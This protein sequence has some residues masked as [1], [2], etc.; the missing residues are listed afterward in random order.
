MFLLFLISFSVIFVKSRTIKDIFEKIKH[1]FLDEI[2]NNENNEDLYEL[3]NYTR[4]NPQDPDYFYVPIF[5]TSDIHGHF[6][7]EEFDLDEYQ[8]S[9]GGLD[10][11][12]KYINII[13]NEFNNQFLYFDAGDMFQGGTE[14]GMSNGEI[15]LDY[16]NLVNTNGSTFGNHEFDYNRSFTEQ[17]VNE[18]NFPFVAANLYDTEKSTKKV[19][20][21]NHFVSYI[22]TFTSEENVKVK[23]GVIGLTLNLNKDQIHGYGYENIRFLDYKNELVKEANDIRSKNDVKAI[24]LLSHLPTQCGANNNLTLNLYKPSDEQEPCSKDSDLYKLLDSL[25]E[26][27]I[28]AVVTGHSH[29]EAH[30]FINNIPVISP[31]NNGLYANILYLAF[32]KKNNYKINRDEVRIEGPLPIC[33]RIFNKTLKCDFVKKSEI[34]EYLPLMN[35]QFHGVKIEKDPILQ[36]IHDKYDEEYSKY[37]QTLCKITGTDDVLRV[38]QNGSFYIGNIIADMHRIVTGANISVVSYGSLRTTWNPGKLPKYKVN[39]LL[40]FGNHL[41]SFIMNGKEVSKMMKILQTGII[42]KYYVTSG[43]KQLMIKDKSGEYYLADIKL[44]DG[45]KEYELN[46]EK[47]YKIATSD[48]LIS[49]GDDFNKVVTW[50]KPRNLNCDYGLQLDSAVEYLKAQKI[51]NVGKYMDDDNPRIRFVGN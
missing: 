25:D 29:R 9:Q 19:F 10:Y 6:Y 47:E 49:G 36:P 41:C 1:E 11:V 15:I 38:Y 40:P 7:P 24:V 44:F 50:Y 23:I 30:H 2:Q 48:Y 5:S 22:Y 14:S 16:L 21:D 39:D 51:V 13:R 12:A 17:K 31:V 45:L 37:N 43:L 34:E 28:D 27:T 32:D 4:I 8:Y 26:G 33:D 35:Y 42:K 20:G 46:P 18:S 3:A